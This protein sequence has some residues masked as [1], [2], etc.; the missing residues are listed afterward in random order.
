MSCSDDN[1][2]VADAGGKL[3]G[4]VVDG[5][6]VDGPAV[7]GHAADG[8]A[9]D[10]PLTDIFGTLDH[11][12]NHDGI[13]ITCGAQVG[14][15]TTSG[16][17]GGKP[18][19]ATHA[20]GVSVSLS[21]LSGFGIALLDQGGT[22]SQLAAAMSTPKL[23]LLL[24]DNKP[25]VHTIGTNCLGGSGGIS[26]KNQASIP[27]MGADIKASGGTITIT[28]LDA[29]CG[30]QV[31]GSF[32]LQFGADEISGSFDSVGCGAISM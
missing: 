18:I 11:N 22:C 30:K 19:G 24:C 3:D 27:Q 6:A 31:K 14:T 21:G 16:T 12:P 23:W 15:A 4:V 2:N 32:K 29:A 28:T 7:D 26:F 13:N 8:H 10:G 25:G 9:A 1:S 17:V 20:G 5:P